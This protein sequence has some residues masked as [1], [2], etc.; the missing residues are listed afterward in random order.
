M[1]EVQVWVYWHGHVLPE[2][3]RQVKIVDTYA[4][5]NYQLIGGNNTL[6]YS[7]YGGNKQFE[8][9]LKVVDNNTESVELAKP[10]L[11]LDNTEIPLYKQSQN[12]ES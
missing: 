5:N 8:Y 4:E 2:F 11:Y 6:Q 7:G 1:I 3:M 9:L 12:F 10:R